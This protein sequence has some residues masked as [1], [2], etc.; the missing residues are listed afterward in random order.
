MRRL[1]DI[2]TNPKAPSSQQPRPGTKPPLAEAPH[3][4]ADERTVRVSQ[5][6]VGR[7]LDSQVVKLDDPS[8]VDDVLIG[9]PVADHGKESGTSSVPEEAGSSTEQRTVRSNHM[10]LPRAAPSDQEEQAPSKPPPKPASKPPPIPKVLPKPL[11]LDL[12]SPSKKP[13]MDDLGVYAFKDALRKRDLRADEIALAANRFFNE[14]PRITDFVQKHG[15]LPYMVKE[16]ESS[17][18]RGVAPDREHMLALH[19]RDLVLFVA[20]CEAN[21]HEY[22]AA[23][24]GIKNGI[25]DRR[26]SDSFP[27]PA[28][29]S[30]EHESV[31]S[32]QGSSGAH[33][34][35]GTKGFKERFYFLTGPTTF[36]FLG[37]AAFGAALHAV[38]GFQELSYGI[39][40]VLRSF[41]SGILSLPA[42]LLEKTYFIASSLVLLTTELA[43]R[44]HM[45]GKAAHY[46]RLIGELPRDL[47][48]AYSNVCKCLSSIA[49]QY[50][51]SV[52]QLSALKKA[53]EDESFFYM[54]DEL[55]R[56][57]Y[58]EPLI[59]AIIASGLNGKVP[60][61]DAIAHAETKIMRPKLERLLEHMDDD[62]PRQA[63]FQSMYGSDAVFRK[64]SEE[65]LSVDRDNRF[66]NYKRF[67]VICNQGQ[68][69]KDEVSIKRFMRLLRRDL[70]TVELGSGKQG[71]ST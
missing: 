12:G 60:T 51:H 21:A 23:K 64:K 62:E 53:L 35:T 39:D 46:E 17:M 40:K 26:D 58:G 10:P 57:S 29:Y 38:G 5:S 22:G 56:H 68:I 48:S 8:A 65:L 61:L 49:R 52:D 27:L 59:A 33:L 28:R 37:I 7:M 4:A 42:D 31:P 34:M 16:A 43:R 69:A 25:L 50:A 20:E 67:A 11:P 70:V 47:Q 30:D 36:G 45:R 54:I 32:R 66:V 63:L 9:A 55:N 19:I 44:F 41:N 71:R 14:D 18:Q 3:A 2:L 1:S 15:D 24:A 6:E 13:P